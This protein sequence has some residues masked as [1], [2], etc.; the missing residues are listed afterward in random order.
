MIAAKASD[1]GNAMSIEQSIQRD[2]GRIEGKIDQFI[3]QMGIQDDRFSAQMAAQDVRHDRLE[4]R[5]RTV[6]NRQHWYAGA[7]AA[8]GAAG[9]WLGHRL[10][11]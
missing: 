9:S 10:F 5:V 1:S 7:A 4:K 11:G 2:L 6:E 3:R 8:V